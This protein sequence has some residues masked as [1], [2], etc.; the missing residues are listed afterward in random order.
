MYE[1]PTETEPGIALVQKVGTRL[2]SGIVA[3]NDPGGGVKTLGQFR[4][5]LRPALLRCFSCSS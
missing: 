4:A 1:L 3:V 2:R 5:R